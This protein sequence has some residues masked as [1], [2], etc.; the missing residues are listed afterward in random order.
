[1]RRKNGRF[2]G[3]SHGVF[4]GKAVICHSFTHD[5][6]RNK[7]TVS[8]VQM[9]DSGIDAKCPQSLD[10]ANTD[11]QL[12]SDAGPLVTTIQSTGQFAIFRAIALDIAVQQEESDTTNLNF[13]N[14]GE[15]SSVSSINGD[16]QR[17]AIR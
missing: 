1:M 6:D 17:S 16:H 9:V 10:A 7:T 4:E 11:Y 13:P 14:F 15:Q 3:F 2:C 5:F 12:L 8:F